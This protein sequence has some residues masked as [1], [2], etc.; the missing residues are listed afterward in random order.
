MSVT[1]R[2]LQLR[3]NNAHGEGETAESAPGVKNTSKLITAREPKTAPDNK[4]AILKKK[5]KT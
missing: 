4:H 5:V 1:S 2:R 3:K